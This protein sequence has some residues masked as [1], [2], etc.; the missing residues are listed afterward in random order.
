MEDKRNNDNVFIRL[1]ELITTI[2]I[3]V[4]LASAAI[5]L[6]DIIFKP[7]GINMQMFYVVMGTS[8]VSGTLIIFKR[9]SEKVMELATVLGELEDRASN[10]KRVAMELKHHDA[11]NKEMLVAIE[12]AKSK[13]EEHTAY[14]IKVENRNNDLEGINSQ[15]IKKRESVEMELVSIYQDLSNSEEFFDNEQLWQK[16]VNFTKSIEHK[17]D[18]NGIQVVNPENG[19]VFNDK[20]MQIVGIEPT[21]AQEN[22]G[23]IFYCKKP[24]FKRLPNR[25]NLAEVVVYEWKK[26]NLDKTEVVAVEKISKSEGGPERLID[27]SMNEIN[28]DRGDINEVEIEK[29]NDKESKNEERQ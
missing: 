21:T 14:I 11:E 24:G 20:T 10:I 25:I 2:L 17:L 23:K 15:L 12:K 5:L 28:Q 1:F 13:I 7:Q 26:P 29:N 8:L 22:I 19:E 18:D 16:L 9:K 3:L 27:H 6:T 4:T